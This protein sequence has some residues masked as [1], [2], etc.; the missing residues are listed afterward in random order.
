MNKTLQFLSCILAGSILLASCSSSTMIISNPN[1]AKVYL[2]GEFVGET[3][4]NHTDSKIVGSSMVVKIEKEGYVPLISTITKD[5]EINV[6]AIIGGLIVAV[7]FLWTMQYKATHSYEL[8][9]AVNESTTTPTE[10]AKIQNSPKSK[11][12]KLREL[13]QLLDEKIITQQEFEKEKVKVLEDTK[14]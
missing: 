8:Q 5:E 3:P 2:D 13:K 11:L 12:D 7:P 9:Q 14:Q 10:T 1:K 4:Y 6:G